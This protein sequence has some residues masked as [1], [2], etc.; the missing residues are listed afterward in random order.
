ML[1]WVFDVTPEGLKADPA[2]AGNKR[3]FATA[4][5]LAALNV[6]SETPAIRHS[7]LVWLYS[8]DPNG[9]PRASKAMDS[10]LAAP[11]WFT[12]K[13]LVDHPGGAKLPEEIS[14][15]PK[16]LAAW[17]DP[18]FAELITAYR[19]NLIKFRQGG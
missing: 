15:D 18:R 16:W 9:I 3:V 7:N 14:T 10:L 5:V 19:A 8:Q 6:D 12:I 13:A 4:A 2:P 1:A 11:D 17:N